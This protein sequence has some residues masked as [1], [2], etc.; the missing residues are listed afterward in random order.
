MLKKR[1]YAFIVA[2]HADSTLLRLSIPY[3]V[4]LAVAGFAFLGVFTAGF[5]VFHYG[6][7]ALKVVDYNHILAENDDFRFEN[8][9]FRIQTAQLGAK[10]DFLESTAEKLAVVSKFN[11]PTRLGGIGGFSKDSFKQPLPPSAGAPEAL[12]RYNK[13]ASMLEESYR[14]LEQYISKQ[15]LVEATTPNILPLKGYVTGGVGRREDP[16]SGTTIDQHTGLDI[17]APYGTKVYAPADGTVIYAGTREGYGNIVVIDHKFG[18][19]TRYG[20]LSKFDVQ[21]GNRVS[22]HD[23]IGYVGTSGRTTGPHLHFEIW[24]FNKYRD[25]LKVIPISRNN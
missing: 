19:T 24:Q 17:S 2:S 4:L 7:M 5:A 25:P 3:P 21:V 15:T 8:H 14:Q 12:E 23:I 20:H 9:K 10:I 22:R 11:D 1:L 13:S 18:Y 16:F 6:R